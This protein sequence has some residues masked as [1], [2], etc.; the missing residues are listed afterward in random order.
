[1]SILNTVRSTAKHRGKTP[2]QLKTELDDLTCRHTRLTLHF[3]ELATAMK[4]TRKQLGTE[5]VGG[6]EMEQTLR[7]VYAERDEAR[8]EI[9]R[10]LADL[11]ALRA[12]IQPRDTTDPAD[13]TTHPMDARE[14]QAELGDDYLNATR[15][16][17]IGPL[18]AAPFATTR[19][20]TSPT[21]RPGE[22]TQTLRVVIPAAS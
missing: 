20:P 8:A 10:L 16:T 11:T 14:L 19:P 2:T 15:Q 1:M 9:R 6:L 13:Q 21:D 12:T 22:T 18:H 17:W 4:H 7:R 5:V 3:A